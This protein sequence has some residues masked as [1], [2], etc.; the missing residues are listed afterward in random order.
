M[1]IDVPPAWQEGLSGDLRGTL[2]VIGAPDTGKSTFARFLYGRLNARGQPVAYLDGDPGQVTL[3]PPATM[4]V[5]RPMDGDTAFPPRG[6]QWRRFIG[7]VSPRGHMLSML[8]GAA[9]LA[10]AAQDAGAETIV[11]DTCG[12]VDPAQ[13]GLALKLAKIELLGPEVAFA[14]QRAG[15]LEPLLAPLRRRRRPRLVELRPSAAAKARTV[16]QRRAHRA[17]RFAAYFQAARAL[18]ISWDRLAVWP[19]PDFAYHQL[20]ALE[21]GRGFVLG[22]GIVLDAD[23]QARRVTIFTPLA[24]CG[25]EAV[26]ALRLG[27]IVVEPR[28]GQDQRLEESGR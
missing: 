19:A 8:V 23:L 9:A 15:E 10:R 26:Q 3:G 12:L 7:S 11:Y 1:Q 24:S 16:E 21:D 18:T 5:A 14:I 28:T 25:Q 4:T 2:L 27:D 17:G 20:I 22:L 6:E 13:G